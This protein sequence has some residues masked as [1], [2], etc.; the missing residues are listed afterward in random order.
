[1]G[2]PLLILPP[3]V[4]QIEGY[5]SSDHE[6]D[7]RG[8]RAIQTVNGV[9]TGLQID[10]AQPYAKLLKNTRPIAGQVVACERLIEEVRF[11]ESGRGIV[12]YVRGSPASARSRNSPFW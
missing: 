10:K 7:A 5:D 4:L 1:M 11:T 12:S 8:V 3:R 2:T 6:S 9:D